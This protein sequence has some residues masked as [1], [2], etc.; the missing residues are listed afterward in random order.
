[1]SA[2]HA[3]PLPDRLC[4]RGGRGRK[5][6]RL[7]PQRRLQLER[8][9]GRNLLAAGAELVEV[10]ELLDARALLETATMS[11]EVSPA[12]D[13]A[14]VRAVILTASADGGSVGEAV[15]VADDSGGVPLLLAASDDGCEDAPMLRS[16]VED[17]SAG[18][19][20]RFAVGEKGSEDALMLF[21]AVADESGDAPLLF[22]MSEDGSEDAPLRLAFADDSGDVPLLFAMSEDGSEDA[23]ILF[24]TVDESA[25]D[26]DNEILLRTLTEPAATSADAE[27]YVLGTADVTMCEPLTAEDVALLSDETSLDDNEPVFG[28]QLLSASTDT[29]TESASP[30]QNADNPY[31]VNGDGMVTPRDVLLVINQINLQLQLPSE[32]TAAQLPSLYVDV[33]GDRRLDASDSLWLTNVLNQTAPTQDSRA[34]VS[35]FA[36]TLG[37][38]TAS[39]D[40]LRTAEQDSRLFAD[41][42]D[43]LLPELV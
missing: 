4:R 40:E 32:R 26:E 39:T 1:M 37:D 20:T 43:W 7:L 22:A 31:D 6:R 35:R 12:G 42:M 9:E 21:A 2:N 29:A 30:W 23:A 16:A 27:T 11:E 38:L 8:L 13:E 18:V 3:S 41:E 25:V 10:A 5:P 24:A 36:P 33:N 28:P 17:D 15:A 14:A 19:M 34:A